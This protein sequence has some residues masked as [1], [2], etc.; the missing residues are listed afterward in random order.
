MENIM[1]IY[2]DSQSKTLHVRLCETTKYNADLVIELSIVLA[3]Q[4]YWADQGKILYE[5]FKK[6]FKNENSVDKN[7]ISSVLM[8]NQYQTL[9]KIKKSL[10]YF[11]KKTEQE[12]MD[13]SFDDNT[14]KDYY[15]HI[16][17]LFTLRG[18]MWI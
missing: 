11:G 10:K 4:M 14:S 9:K 6:K 15:S 17:S 13:L 2:V 7:N 8:F 5:R 1:P 12:I 16:E 3:A 18:S